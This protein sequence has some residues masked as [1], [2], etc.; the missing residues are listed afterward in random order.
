M[1]SFGAVLSFRI[2]VRGGKVQKN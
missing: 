2:K 1:A